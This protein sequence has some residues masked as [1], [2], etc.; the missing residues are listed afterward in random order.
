MFAIYRAQLKK[1]LI[2]Q[3]QYRVA[4]MIWMIDLI[5][6]PVIYLV[7]W[8]SVANSSG[9]S[10]RGF[11]AADFAAYYIVFMV[12]SHL[13]QIWHMWEYEYNIKMGIFSTK[14]LRPIHPIHE[15]IAHNIAYK[16]LMLVVVI[17]S[18]I[19]LIIV[20][21]PHFAPPLWALAVFPLALL[22]GGAVA[23]FSGWALAMT[24]FWTTRVFAVNHLYFVAMIFFSGQI[25]PLAL[26]P[27]LVKQ[28]GDLL[29]FR[30]MLAFPVELFLGR[31]PQEEAFIG[32]LVQGLWIVV[33]L[34][35][36]RFIWNAAVRR[37]SAVGI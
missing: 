34:I 14:L 9:G 7:V 27:A 18:V 30:W 16:L 1:A 17:P 13:T 4:M 25:A 28:V 31:V 5:L 12:V 19:L 2:I 11:T 24:A 3:F 20:F 10:V 6:Q 37:Y 8:S 32:L 23:F 22:L 36:L 15:D 29:P 26:M 35:A 21:R 33:L